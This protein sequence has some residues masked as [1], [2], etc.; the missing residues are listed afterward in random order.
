MKRIVGAALT[1]W[2]ALLVGCNSPHLAIDNNG[3]LSVPAGGS[4]AI[5]GIAQDSSGV[6]LWKLT[7]PGT[8]AP[9]QGQQ[10]L[11]TAP[12]MFDPKATSATVVGSLSDAPD[13]T[14]TIQITIT[15]P[16]ANVGGFPGLSDPV[17][18][19]YDERDIPTIACNKTVDCYAVLGYIH[20][21]D[22]FF[23]MDFY[24]RVARGTLSELIG[25]V[26][27]DQDIT[28]R[29]LFTTRGGQSVPEVLGAYWAADDLAGPAIKAYV[30]GIN[31]WIAALRANPSL[32]PAEYQTINQ[33]PTVLKPIDPKST[34]DI[35]DWTV[36]DT[37]ALA[38]LQQFQLSGQ[39]D[40]G[41][42]T[43]AGLW[44]LKFQ[45][46]ADDPTAIRLQAWI[47]SL[48]FTRSYT[49]SGSGSPLAQAALAPGTLPDT[50]SHLRD[51]EAL[52]RGLDSRVKAL[53]LFV[54]HGATEPAGSNNWVV[55]GAHATGGKAFVANDP[56]LDLVYPSN[57]HLSH[58]VG[59]QDGLNVMG[60]VFPGIAVVL[61]GRGTHVGF[62]ATV[63]GY[64][65]TEI[66][67]ESLHFAAPGQP[68]GVNYKGPADSAS[69]V[70]PFT[71][72]PQTYNVRTAV[73][74]A[75]GVVQQPV[76][77]VP[78]HGPIIQLSGSQAFSARW[79]GQE[80]Q[81]DEIRAIYRLHNAT[82]VADAMKALDGDPKDG[83]GSYTG[84]FTGAQNWILADDQG[85]IGYDPHACVPLRPW[86]TSKAAVYP[87]PA[88]P[89]PGSGVPA[90]LEWGDAYGLP[91]CV[92]N[93]LLPKSLGSAKGFLA[94]ANGDP[95]G[96]GDD[97]DPYQ[98]D[99]GVP[100]LS[101]D[102][103]DPVGFRIKRIQDTL[104]SKLD[105]GTVSLADVHALQTD[106]V[107]EL[108]RPFL[109]YVTAAGAAAPND[110][111]VQA[112]VTLLGKWTLDCPTGLTTD[113]PSGVA[114]S[115]PTRSTDSAACLLFHT[116]LR[117]VLTATFSD[118]FA[119]AGMSPDLAR[120][121]RALLFLLPLDS[122]ANP[123]HLVCSDID[124]TTG[125]KVTDHSCQ[126][127]V[128]AALSRAYARLRQAWG[129]E[130]NWRWGRVHTLRFTHIAYPLITDPGLNPGPYAR[131]G[132]GTTV[133]VGTP[134][135]LDP[136]DLNFE[137]GSGGNVRWAAAMDGVP[138]NTTIQLPGVQNGG[139]FV[140][141]TPSMLTQWVLNQYFN[142]PFLP[143][144]VTSQ[145]VENYS[146]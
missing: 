31:F 112:A 9:T 2:V 4:V 103:S 28:L 10:T 89:V 21:R 127:Q 124:R 16:T 6:I 26:V 113:D 91:L 100:Y 58:I 35:P 111:N 122:T 123:T 133:D 141:N 118:E 128:T 73:G 52:L 14:Q 110:T 95:L 15:L 49:L 75:N 87:L 13:Q 132:G 19:N 114:D 62:G 32:L 37:A 82:S 78:H 144:D 56:H 90:A 25:D 44:A 106:H 121:L 84:F 92:P 63:V 94:T 117:E 67:Q 3:K 139:P 39:G 70:V 125:Q 120:M 59:Q 12:A 27:L 1:G 86:A 61:I 93:A 50:T 24:R 129:G 18:V 69:H 17:S 105:G 71:V 34:T 43:A 54:R 85:A 135:S 74:V 145:R 45:P 98:N 64:D 83:G 76:L 140:G 33:L 53:Q 88:T 42:K 146:P 116:F 107:M 119:F 23:Q 97:N 20:A 99:A 11:Y 55:D 115:D 72:A 47:R 60:A 142:F 46:G 102:W 68:D 96:T 134:L 38:R 51:T 138:A 81:T 30:Q 108:A 143:G 80:P 5:T 109:P 48:M 77:V 40:L 41:K 79:T 8:L 36:A 29:T 137:Y 126:E 7:G 130:T 101:T 65:V 104:S 22:R 136:N 57:F 131:P 66:Y